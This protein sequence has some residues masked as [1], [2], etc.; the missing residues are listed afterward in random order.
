MDNKLLS[1]LSNLLRHVLLDRAAV[2]CLKT[3]V[4]FFGNQS[5]NIVLHH[6]FSYA[7]KSR[8]L[9]CRPVPKFL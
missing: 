2:V 4:T 1:Y 8:Q 5:Y 3:Y 9:C 7:R 6:I